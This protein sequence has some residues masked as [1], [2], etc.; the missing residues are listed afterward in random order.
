MILVVG[1]TGTNGREVVSRLAAAG[2][3]VRAMVRQPSRASDLRGANVELVAGDLDDPGS[4]DAAWAGV[5][6]AFFVAAVDRRYVGWF[7]RFLAA[8]RRSG[9]PRIVKFSGMGAGSDSPS[10]IMRQ[11]GETDAALADSGLPYTVLRP[12]SFYQNM[13]WS[14]ATIKAQ[15]AFYLPMGDARQSLV[16]VRDIADVAVEVLTNPGHEGNSYAITGPECLSYHEVAAKLSAVLGKPVKYVD[17][18]PDAAFD[19]MLKAGMAEW[20]ARAVT[21]LYT[22]FAAGLAA[23][24]TDTIERITGRRPIAFEQFARDH[25]AAFS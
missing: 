17:V 19:S 2:H 13:L 24:T 20:N 18:P 7:H 6:R 4:L 10:E 16:D 5:D 12:N 14:A 23:G 22:V 9:A 3:R 21:E 8:A 25:A 15:G 1:A 11:H